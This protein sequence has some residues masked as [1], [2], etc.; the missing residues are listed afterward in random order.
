MFPANRQAIEEEARSK[1]LEGRTE[2]DGPVLIRASDLSTAY[3]GG[4]Q[5]CV[6]WRYA[7]VTGVTRELAT[8]HSGQL[9][10]A[11]FFEFSFEGKVLSDAIT[12]T[13]ERRK[14]ALPTTERPI[15]FTPEFFEDEEKKRQGSAF[16]ACTMSRQPVGE[17]ATHP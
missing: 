11:W 4:A 2:R 1:Y 9:Q 3:C 7:V 5:S 14:T 6:V 10:A 17:P 16:I 13:F 8:V 12:R 15:A